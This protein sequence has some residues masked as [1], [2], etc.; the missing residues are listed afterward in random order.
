MSKKKVLLVDANFANNTLTRDFA[1]KPTLESFSMNGHDSNPERI[2][3]ITTITNI[4][5][6]DIIGCEEGNYTPSEILSKYNLFT[7]L[8]KIIDQYDFV[9]IEA[10]ATQYACGQQGAG[11]ICRRNHFGVLGQQYDWRPR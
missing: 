11:G 4:T 3:E 8:D 10:A 6:I 5:N 2:W 9:F 7:N 1:A